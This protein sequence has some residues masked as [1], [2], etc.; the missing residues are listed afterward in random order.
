MPG[1]GHVVLRFPLA[2]EGLWLLHCHVLWHQG[3]GMG[4]VLQVGEVPS[5]QSRER[6]AELCSRYPVSG[7]ERREV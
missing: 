2:N 5:G 7:R 3:V 1:N 4:I 6:A